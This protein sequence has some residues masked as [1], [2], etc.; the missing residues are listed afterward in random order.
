MNN[1]LK[2]ITITFC[3]LQEIHFSSRAHRLKAKV[4]K[5]ALHVNVNQERSDYT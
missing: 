5:Q 4:E 2:K 1:G 3:C